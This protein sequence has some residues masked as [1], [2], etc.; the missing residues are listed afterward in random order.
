[1]RVDTHSISAAPSGFAVLLA[2]TVMIACS[3]GTSKTGSTSASGGVSG[4]GGSSDSSAGGATASSV[5][6]LYTANG[7]SNNI[8]GFKINRDGTLTTLSGFPMSTTAPAGKL[9]AAKQS[10]LL[11]GSDN[12][13]VQLALYNIAPGTGQLTLQSSTTSVAGLSGVLDPNAQY[14]YVPSG[15]PTTSGTLSGFN[16]SNGTFTSTPGSPYQFAISG[17]SNPVFAQMVTVDPDAKFIYMPLNLENQHT[18]SGWF[19]VATRNSSDGSIGGFN[20]YA[21]GC[22]SAGGMAILPQTGNTL[23]YSSCVDQSNG[24]FWIVVVSIDQSTGALTDLGGAWSDPTNTQHIAPLAIDRSGK[25]LAGVDVQ[26][27]IVHI[28]AINPNGK[29]TDSN[30]HDFATGSSPADVAFDFTGKFLYIINGGSNN[31][32]AYAFDPSTGLL[33]DLPGSPYPTGQA[34]GALAIAQP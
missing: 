12:S 18:P 24:Q 14:A 31:I 7:G 27:N 15:S 23:V 20:G 33:T 1:M 5:Q 8:S 25:W 19:G 6:Y 26:N 2:L 17:G 32:G 13:G 16:V 4:T 9:S 11:G 21:A 30:N 29:L 22:I 3:G 10:L 34:P 28:M